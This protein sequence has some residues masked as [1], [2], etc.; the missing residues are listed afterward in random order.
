MTPRAT[1]PILASARAAGLFEAR[2]RSST[3][4]LSGTK[5]IPWPLIAFRW[6]LASRDYPAEKASCIRGPRQMHAT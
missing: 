3:L 1:S 4:A 5:L 2:W 6:G